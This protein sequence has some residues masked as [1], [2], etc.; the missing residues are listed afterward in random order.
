MKIVHIMLLAERLLNQVGNFLNRYAF[1]L[2]IGF[3]GA[4]L[5]AV[6]LEVI[7]RW[8][9]ATFIWTEELSKWLL[10]W[11]AFIGASVVLKERAHVRIEF[12]ISICP[13]K[14]GK[15]VSFIADLGVL[16]FLLYFTVTCWDAAVDALGVRGDVILVPL[17]YPKLGMPIAGVLM[18]I[19]EVHAIIANILS[20]K[21]SFQER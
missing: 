6:M 13:K 14:I 3:L 8:V 18:I 20:D 17:F 19:H 16:F 7:T 21:A 5:T 9:G 12:F 2:C 1:M 4:D 15:L 10:N 11:I